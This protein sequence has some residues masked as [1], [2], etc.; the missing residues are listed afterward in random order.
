MK[1]YNWRDEREK[2]RPDF[3]QKKEA[4][5]VQPPPEEP[6][7]DPRKIIAVIAGVI[8]IALIAVGVYFF[9]NNN[10]S[11]GKG[12]GGSKSGKEPP[13][14]ATSPVKDSATM[15]A[16]AAAKQKSA[17]GVVV[18]T[19]ELKDGRKLT[20]EIG[21]AW[22][23][24][25]DKFATNAHVAVAI[26]EAAQQLKIQL[27]SALLK[28]YAKEE[29]CND[30]D[31]LKKKVG[32]AKF[33]Q[34]CKQ[35]IQF[36]Q[37]NTKS[38]SAA[39]FIN[40]AHGKCYTITHY[41]IHQRYGAKGT[42]VD[43]DVAVLTI[44]GKHDTFFKIAKQDTLHSLKAGDP[45]A[46]LGFPMENLVHN[47]VNLDNPVASMQTGNIVAVSDF[48]LKD[49]GKDANLLIRHNLPSTGGASGSPIFNKNGEVVALLYAGHIIRQ[50]DGTRAPSAAMINMSVRVDL[51]EG[52]GPIQ[53]ISDMFE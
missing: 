36:V 22:A 13:V 26:K 39:I 8:V 42:A 14:E 28:S 31:A 16:E 34:L 11:E 44:Q 2:F 49:S 25:E 4:P 19:L 52:M 15:L 43:P 5:A 45:I 51:L 48:E 53:P 1:E 27:A 46:F 17:V 38:V 35:A 47:N 6:R 21:T 7:T 37:Q 50:Q 33:E 32:E 24:A 9:I 29:G 10:K 3:Q 23:F 40:G 18:V 30:L 41:Q 12:T 20:N